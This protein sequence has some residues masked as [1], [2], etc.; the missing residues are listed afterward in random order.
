MLGREANLRVLRAITV[1]SWR[2]MWPSQVVDWTGLSRTGVWNALHRLEEA[3]IIEPVDTGHGRVYPFR[4][5]ARNRL[6]D[7]LQKLF[8]AEQEVVRTGI[9]LDPEKAQSVPRI[10]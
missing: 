5:T 8:W 1:N 9:L 4:F 3:W 7:P 2:L 6:A 10:W